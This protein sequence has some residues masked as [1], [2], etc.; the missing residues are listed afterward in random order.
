ETTTKEKINNGPD[1]ID[2]IQESF[3]E[4]HPTKE[5]PPKKE[6]EVVEQSKYM[7]SLEE[8][9]FKFCEESI[10]KQDADDEWIRKSIKN[11]ESNIRILR[12]TTKNLQEKAYQLT[13][14]I[15]TDTCEKVKND[16][17]T[18]EGTNR[19]IKGDMDVDWDIAVEDIERLRQFLTPTIH[20]LHNL[21]PVVQPYMSL[22]PVH[23]KDKIVREVEQD[24]DIPLHDGVIQPLTPQIV[25]VTPHNDDYVA[26]ATS[27][28]LDM[29]LNEFGK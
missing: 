17:G 6:D 16:N 4:A 5:C 25:R 2:D 1:K 13:H 29:Q 8:T 20:T 18:F 27:P 24:Y 26:S 14:T 28:T 23:D 15:L 12:T 9:I 21:E 7:R 3:K 11:T 19:R 10:K 22:G